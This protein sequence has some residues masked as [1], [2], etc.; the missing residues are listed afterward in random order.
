MEVKVIMIVFPLTVGCIDAYFWLKF[1][2]YFLTER[3]KKRGMHVL[4]TIAAVLF[5]I[6]SVARIFVGEHKVAIWYTYFTVVITLVLTLLG[7]V[8]NK[9]ER[10]FYWFLYRMVF[11]TLDIVSIAIIDK[12]MV[13]E[14]S[15]NYWGLIVFSRVL[16]IAV[17]SFLKAKHPRQPDLK[18]HDLIVLVIVYGLCSMIME[19]IHFSLMT[20]L[21]NLTLVIEQYV[22]LG[23]VYVL[24]FGIG[25][26][27]YYAVWLKSIEDVEERLMIQQMV[28][29]RQW[30]K[31]IEEE[32][33]KLRIL[34]HDMN[35]HIAVL[36]LLCDSGQEDE[37]KE[38]IEE[39]YHKIE[40]AN[41]VVVTESTTLASL[42]STKKMRA[43][44]LGIKFDSKLILKEL[45]I[46]DMDISILF[47]NLLD[48]AIEAAQKANKKWIDLVVE[49]KSDCFI[50]VCENSYKDAPKKKGEVFV[51]S[52]EDEDSHGMG[53]KSMKQVIEKYKGEIAISF[54]NN[55]FTV[56]I[57]I[58]K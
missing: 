10:M 13:E 12:F 58:K 57:Q 6:L 19:L 27:L 7:Y 55:V 40:R 8:N 2:G 30:K 28:L 22:F 24:V 35:N 34:R 3:Y 23:L 36:K 41:D 50:V 51:T 17:V 20:H 49:E 37:L 44:D 53:I 43:K 39:M 29:E 33:K 5:S 45:N 4:M 21:N 31:D 46:S 47:G 38:Y 14:D 56:K 48:N 1:T 16:M 32:T 26:A 18:R 11:V 52:K 15:L 25:V 42:V 54:E 9:K